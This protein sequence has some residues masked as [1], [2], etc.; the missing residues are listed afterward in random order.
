MKKD[1]FIITSTIN[2]GNKG[3]TYINTRSIFT[4]QERYE[5]T[6]ETIKSIKKHHENCW[7]ILSE[8]SFI[9]PE[10]VETL[11]KE[12]D[13]FLH[14]YNDQEIIDSCILSNKKGLGELVI[15]KKT[16]DYIIQNPN[17]LFISERIY[18]IS[19]RYSLNEKYDEKNFSKS[20]YTFQ[21]NNNVSNSFNT[22]LYSFPCFFLQDFINVLYKSIKY[23]STV[24]SVSVEDILGKNLDP[25]H[26][27]EILGVQGLCATGDKILWSR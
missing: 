18:K 22:V 15:L 1:I 11:S 12:V 4:P 19:G 17:I 14:L 26:I 16:F 6:L 20:C 2:T 3:W 7:I 21:R 24:Y 27:V 9:P 8:A 10:Q 23:Y 5:Q 13:A 25:K